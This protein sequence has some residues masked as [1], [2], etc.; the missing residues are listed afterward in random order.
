MKRFWNWLLSLFKKPVSA[1]VLTLVPA[2][3]APAPKKTRARS[4]V[5]KKTLK[6]LLDNIEDTF[7]SYTLPFSK[8]SW[9]PKNTATGL[10]K[11]GVHVVHN[12]LWRLDDTVVN[13]AAL[14]KMPGIFCV[15]FGFAKYDSPKAL[16]ACA[17]YGV[18]VFKLPSFVS[19]HNGTHYQFGLALR[20]GRNS[21]NDT[22]KDL[23]WLY[24]YITVTSK[25]ALIIHEEMKPRTHIVPIKNAA[26]R[27]AVGSKVLHYHNKEWGKAAI[28]DWCVP[29]E[30]LSVAESVVTGDYVCKLEFAT[31]I[32]WWVKRNENWSVAVTHKGDRVTF[33]VPKEH[34]SKYFKDRVKVTTANGNTRPIVHYVKEFE[35]ANGSVVKDHI[36]GLA[37]FDW[38]GYMCHV[39]APKFNGQ[40][41]SEF[42][43]SSEE[44]DE[45]E[46]IPRS[47]GMVDISKIG[48]VLAELENRKTA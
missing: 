42:E 20:Q 46:G 30:Q 6:G 11:L 22:E 3:I 29:A 26:T 31:A 33:A 12:D 10:R 16:H 40:L 5:T 24:G 37:D 19:K 18:K 17:I 48:S 21:C 2:A 45:D 27:R 25:G 13:E 9:I 28:A 44:F 1:T 32:N 7:H 38:H 39:T 15:N 35:R 8:Y 43:M 36:R 41:S 34:T 47:A 4:E 23:V 14:A